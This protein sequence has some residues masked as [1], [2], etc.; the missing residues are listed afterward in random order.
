MLARLLPDPLL[1]GR[2]Q[3]IRPHLPK[4]Q[5]QDLQVQRA[6]GMRKLGTMLFRALLIS[7]LCFPQLLK[8]KGCSGRNMTHLPIITPRQYVKK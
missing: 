3:D 8:G 1:H 2:F 5:E 4:L 7:Y 6:I